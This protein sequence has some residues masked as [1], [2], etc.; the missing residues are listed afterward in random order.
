MCRMGS[1]TINSDVKVIRPGSPGLFEYLAEVWKYRVLV[2]T[3]ASQELKT[4]YVQTKLGALW[5]VLRPLMVILIFT[6]IFDKL[7]HIPGLKVPYPL[8]AFSG[9]IAW[10][11]FSYVVSAGGNAVITGQQLI[12]KVYFPKIILPL[13]KAL[14]GLVEFAVSF[15][16]LLLLMLVMGYKPGWTIVFLPVFVFI[17][18]ITGLT[19]AIW[20]NALN[21][22]F[23]DI[24]QFVPQ[25]I[26]FLIWL[27]PVFYPGTLVPSAYSFVLYL[28]PLAG[29]IQGYRYCILHDAAP[30]WQYGVAFVAVAVAFVAG[31]LVFIKAEDQM[32]DYL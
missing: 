9:L 27:T 11:Y 15:A 12:R 29:I 13:S 8:F 22:R 19:V 18:L 5:A 24:N 17:N 32:A 16:L 21:V 31:L 14:V 1:A 10:N 3:F 28:N 2:F 26:G 30:S 20:L 7:I 6:F 23:R 25:L 4:Q